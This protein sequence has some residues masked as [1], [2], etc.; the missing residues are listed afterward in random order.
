MYGQFYRFYSTP[1]SYQELFVKIYLQFHHHSSMCVLKGSNKSMVYVFLSD[2][3][4][5]N[6]DWFGKFAISIHKCTRRTSF[7]KTKVQF[8][9]K[10]YTVVFIFEYEIFHKSIWRVLMHCF[11]SPNKTWKFAI[12]YENKDTWKFDFWTYVKLFKNV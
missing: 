11:F 5:I 9:V 3:Q 1:G 2:M 4:I 7:W 12:L 6:I 10:P 8:K